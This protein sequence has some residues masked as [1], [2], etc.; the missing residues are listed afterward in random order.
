M[1]KL[2]GKNKL[3]DGLSYKFIKHLK[4]GGNGSVWETEHNGKN[5]AIKILNEDSKEKK[6]R[7]L[8][9]IKFCE[10]NTHKN[11]IKIYGDGEIDG[12]LCYVMSLYKNNLS[13]I[14][15]NRD[16]TIEQSFSYIFQIC[17]GLKFIH[18]NNVIHRDLK[19]ENILVESDSLVL[20][21]LGIAHFENSS[22]T[23]TNDLLAN[24]GYAAPEQKVKG[25][26]RTISSA[27]DIF[28]LGIIIN[29][30]FTGKKPEGTNFIL[31]SDL[32][33]WLIDIDKLVEKC[34]R[35]NPEERIT[36]D[37]VLLE[38]KLKYS[39]LEKEL[40]LIKYSLNQDFNTVHEYDE[41]MKRKIIKQASEDILTA[42]YLFA[43]KSAE[44][45]EQYNHNY[46]CNVRYKINSRLRSSYLEYLI[47]KRC[48]QTFDYESN[49]YKN[50]NSYKSLDL[51]NVDDKKIY[52]EF[53]Y[54]LK[55]NIVNLNGEILKMFS[56]CCNYHCEEIIKSL[57]KLEEQVEDL[58]D[59]PILYII[60]KLKNMQI[61]NSYD[62]NLIE[63][64]ILVNWD[65]TILNY[66]DTDI[67][68][69]LKKEI[70]DSE[71]KTILDK[72]SKDYNS[73]ISKS[74]EGYVIRFED[75]KSYE[76]FKKYSLNL[77][78]PYYIFEGD[79][80]DILRIDREFEGII[81][82]KPWNSFDVTNVLAKILGL[83]ND[84]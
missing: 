33:P 45:L 64:S 39:Q 54:Y 21:D 6:E 22:I 52:L 31:I 58:N 29:E 11:L 32:Y 53:E 25:M 3:I 82:L 74:T 40:D 62:E 73:I 48:K 49:V 44:E 63:D 55:E 46:H 61:H 79:V 68:I 8:Q 24:R 41:D 1:S 83:R 42:T 38:L 20:A 71:E 35:Q 69:G 76:R 14:I 16:L 2:K 72:F 81:E 51:N 43:N 19:P 37:E 10:K 15:E 7:F 78:K 9:E 23:K 4:N 47:Y 50:G 77:S 70:N 59:A 30:I 66:D 67:Y 26:S 60:M 27:A 65:K 17:E 5:Y 13:D 18:N 12:K 75:K 36:I 28:S 57:G 34:M 56:S 84:Y 80:L